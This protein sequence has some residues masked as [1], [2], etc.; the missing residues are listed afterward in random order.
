MESSCL[1]SDSI[2]I[3]GDDILYA[4][5]IHVMGLQAISELQAILANLTYLFASFKF[6]I[7]NYCMHR[8]TTYQLNINKNNIWG[9]Y[10]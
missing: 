4:I 3:D 10:G 8:Y 9:F 5:I 1:G 2:S 6:Y 7:I